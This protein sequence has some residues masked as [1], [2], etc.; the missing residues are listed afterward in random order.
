[1]GIL[2]L[3]RYYKDITNF[4]IE[5]ENKE[6]LGDDLQALKKI[7]IK[8][9]TQEPFDVGESGT[10]YRFVKFYTWKMNSSRPIH[11]AGTLIERSKKMFKDSSAIFYSPEE[12]LKLDNST[13]Q[14]ATMAYLLGD[15]RKVEN[16]PFKLK[17]TYEAV[18]HWE[19]KRKNGQMWD[20][21]VD[22]TILNQAKEFLKFL[23]RGK[24]NFLPEQ[25]EDYC[26]ARAFNIIDGET[27]QRKFPSLI[28]HETNRIVEMERTIMEAEKNLAITTPDH[29]AV[30]AIVMKQIAMNKPYSIV[31]RNCVNK[32]WPKFWDFIENI[33]SI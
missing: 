26:F 33:K 4:L 16:P 22:Q 32:T 21:R 25:A 27:G 23:D 11:L 19:L 9:D 24:M 29:R 20:E 1:M 7:A 3:T 2:D 10:I 28:G 18:E 31:N 6:K 30:Q 14:W 5:K 13:S 12:L 15:K 17:N 8:W